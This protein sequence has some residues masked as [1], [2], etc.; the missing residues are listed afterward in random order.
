MTSTAIIADSGFW[1]ALFNRADK[2]HT[3]A[4]AALSG[5]ERRLITT[6]PVMTETCH[7]LLR[8]GGHKVQQEFVSQWVQRRFDIFDVT[9]AHSSKIQAL[10][11]KYIDLPMDLADASLVLLAGELGHGD[12]LT[13]DQRDFRAY[14]WKHRRPFRNLLLTE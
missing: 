4:V 8:C 5:L 13:T 11:H 9:H 10:M 2:F 6:W 12:I 7:I 14:R 3:P 1:I